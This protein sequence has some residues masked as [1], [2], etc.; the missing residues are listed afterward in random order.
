MIIQHN[1]AA[2]HTMTQLGINNTNF[3]KSTERLSSGYRINRAADDAAKLSISEKKRSQIRGLRRAAKNAEDGVSFVQTSDEAMSQM[4]NILHRMRELTIQSLNDTNTPQ[5]RAAMQMEFDELQSELDRINDQTE[6][7]KISVFEHYPDTYY[8]IEGNRVWPQDQLHEITSANQTL[9]ITYIPSADQGEKTIQ[10]SI[11]AGKYTTQELIDEMDDVVNALGDQAGGLALEYSSDNTCNMVL[12]NG[13]EITSLSGGLSYLFFND[14]QGGQVSSL[15][16]TTVFDPNFPLII[17]EKNN[18][19]KFTIEN[20]DG[21]TNKIELTIP[22]GYYSRN[23][24][25]DTLNQ[26]LAGTGITA[27]EYGDYSIQLGGDTGFITGLKGNMFRIEDTN[28]Q[29]MISVFYDN[30]KYGS[31]QKTNGYFTGGAVLVNRVADAECNHFT[32]DD[33]NNILRIRV[34]GKDG[35][36]FHEIKL[37]SGQYLM[38]EMVT[39]L[40]SKL[41]AAGLDVS[42]SSYSSSASVSPNGN[43]YSFYGLRLFSESKGRDSKIEFDIPGSSAYETLFTKRTYTDSGRTPSVFNGSYSYSKPSI[44]GGRTFTSSDFPLTLD[45]T[46]NTFKINIAEKTSSGSTLVSSNSSYAITLPEKNYSSLDEILTAINTQLNG[47]SAPIGLKNK[48]QAVNLNDTIQLVPQDSNRTVTKITFV[49]TATSPYKEGYDTLFVGKKTTYSTSSISAT[50]TSP[51]LTLDTLTEPIVIDDTNNKLTVNV[52]GENRNVVIPPGTYTKDQLAEEITNQLKG[53]ETTNPVSFSG[54]GV[55]TTTDKNQSFSATGADNRV[56]IR[57]NQTGTGG[58]DEGSTTI[59]GGTP[60]TYTVPVTLPASTTVNSENNQFSIEVNS[61][62]YHIRLDNG[63]YTPQQLAN[64]FQQ[65]LSQEITDEFDK[66]N[67][68]LSDGKLVFTTANVGKHISMAFGAD[69]SSFLDSIST[70]KTA[71]SIVTKP[72]Q[73]SIVIGADSNTFSFTIDGVRKNV[74]L[75][76]GNYSRSDFIKELNQQFQNAGIGA[77]ASLTGSN[78]CLT[79]TEANGALSSL[80]F[81]TKNCGNCATALFGELLTKGPACASVNTPLQDNIVISPGEDE[82]KVRITQNGSSHTVSA[83][84]PSGTYTKAEMANKLNELLG[85]EMTVNLNSSGGLSFTTL[86]QG[87]DVSIQVNNSISGSAGTALFG[88]NTVKKPDVTASFTP[89]G[90]LVL[91][92]ETSSSYT[93][94]A[95]PSADSALLKPIPTTQTTYPSSTTGN[96][97]LSYFHLRTNSPVPAS[98]QIADYSNDLHFLYNFPGGQ[99]S[100]DLTLE[101]KNYNREELQNAL[102]DKID[103]A[104]G[105][106]VLTVK[107]NSSEIQIKA[108]NYRADYSISNLSGGF[109]K[110]IMEGTA[111]RGSTQTPYSV[112]GKQGV[113]DTY[114]IGRKDV[115]NTTSVIRKDFSDTLNLDV[116]IDN[117]VHTLHLTLDPGSYS[118][119]ALVQEIQKKLDEQV[120]AAGLPAHSI[121]AAVGKFDTGVIGADDKN[122]LDIYL[123]PDADLE[124]GSYRIDGLTGNSL[125]EIFYKTTGELVPAYVAGSKDISNGLTISPDKNEFTI[126]VDGTTYAYTIP[127]GDYSQEE[128]IEKLN[129]LFASPDAHGNTSPLEASASGDALKISHKRMGKHQIGNVQG[130]AK[131]DMFYE[132]GGRSDYT[133][134]LFLQIGANEEQSTNLKRFCM[135]SLSLGINSVAITQRKYADKALTRLDEALNKLNTTRSDYG[136]KQNR[137]EY[138]IKGNEN[139]SENLQASESRD[140][141]TEM[142]SEMVQYAK[143]Q[144]LMQ[145]GTAMLTQANQHTQSVLSLLNS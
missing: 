95:K 110:Y 102:Q 10:L 65:K 121:L 123:N 139:T 28:E 144:I 49:S 131:A 111:V 75:T 101:E 124:P 126:D 82:F 52:A 116:T 136:A 18:E 5:D 104:L 31:V 2:I 79:T 1:M 50:G 39:E 59:V 113:S 27:S 108:V 24:M 36:A 86:A 140:R 74:A 129:D 40:Q 53:S 64:A 96:V 143:D 3:K 63:N 20:F 76:A 73:S 89:D 100:V 88:K 34:D 19:L 55:G 107:V 99:T 29:V 14:Y 133:S 83:A 128:F 120:V 77:K 38:G 35:E 145:T 71:A 66:V 109:Y 81:D 54:Y 103:A 93:L 90:K 141:D 42:V 23:K 68:S 117:T 118:S 6:F 137:L 41:D 61:N 16:G 56:T 91:T 94:S 92:G 57:C 11:P 25:I 119:D 122:A 78:L 37:D 127:E 67:V 8:K 33:T 62:L 80:S 98:T 115:R 112:D 125:F 44:T 142:A 45:S 30:T 72:L 105:S 132:M 85:S 97:S 134:D 12:Q 46:I 17:N 106:G 135:S 51:S 114:I 4:E 69:T 84:I 60:A 13:E 47:N 138:T 43:S 7:N 15:I 87:K 130:S 58:L 9:N 32:I 48:I 21:T 22:S 26:K 70:Q